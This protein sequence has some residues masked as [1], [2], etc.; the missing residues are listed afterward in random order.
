MPHV[1]AGEPDGRQSSDPDLKPS[2]FRPRYRQLTNEERDLH[3]MIKVKA[4][5]IEALI[6]ATNGG[7]YQALAMTAL[8]ESI[9]WA[10]KGLTA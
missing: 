10:I 9:M 1:F 2:R 7:R 8:E 4:A 6:E 5:E 3:D